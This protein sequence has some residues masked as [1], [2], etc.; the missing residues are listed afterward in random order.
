M[1]RIFLMRLPDPRLRWR[2]TNSGRH[3]NK[4]FNVFR[5]SR[6]SA[7][8]AEWIHGDVKECHSLWE[9]VVKKRFD[10]IGR[11]LGEVQYSIDGA[12]HP[13]YRL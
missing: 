4:N 7:H 9:S 11:E 13:L 8:K 5:R 3:R 12:D 10:D 6:C 2:I 1:L